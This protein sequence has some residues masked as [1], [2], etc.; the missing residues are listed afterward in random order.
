MKFEWPSASISSSGKKRSLISCQLPSSQSPRTC[1]SLPS[2]TSAGTKGRLPKGVEIRAICIHTQTIKAQQ[3][4]SASLHFTVSSMKC[5]T[6][7][8]SNYSFLQKTER[9][10]KDTMLMMLFQIRSSFRPMMHLL[11]RFPVCFSARHQTSASALYMNMKQLSSRSLAVQSIN[12]LIELQ[13]VTFL[14]LI[15]MCFK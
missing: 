13:W 11:K 15:C 10:S 12:H 8:R 7:Q 1:S 6:P 4:H 3:S 5:K 9:I 14:T 2:I